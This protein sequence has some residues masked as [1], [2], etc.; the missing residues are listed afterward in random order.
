MTDQCPDTIINV[1]ADANMHASANALRKKFLDAYGEGPGEIHIFFAPGR[2]NLIGEHI[3]Y[4]GGYVLPVALSL[5][6]YAAVRYAGTHP[7]Q[8]NIVHL[9]SVNEPGKVSV[10]LSEE[11]LFEAARGW[12]NY[13]LGVIQ[14]L[15]QHNWSGVGWRLDRGC[16]LG[17]PR[18]TAKHLRG[19]QI[20]YWGNLPVGAGLSSSAAIEVLTGYLMLY[21]SMKDRFDSIQQVWLAQLC[22]KAEN[23]FIKV[24]CG[25]MDQF[26][27]AMGK[28]NQAVLLDCVSLDCRYVPVELGDYS[29][30][31]M[32]T[33]KRRSLRESRYNRRRAE[34]EEALGVIRIHGCCV[35]V[36]NLAQ[37]TLEQLEVLRQTIGIP[38]A[39]G[40]P[41]APE[42]SEAPDFMLARHS[43][44]PVLV[45]RARHVLT[46][47]QRTIQAGEFLS[48]G[49][50]L[51][52]GRLMTES[53][54]SL[55]YD[56]EVTGFELDAIVEAALSQDCC[57]GARMTGAGFGG[58]AIALVR[59]YSLDG[60]K[61]A[62]GKE[63]FLKT[64]LRAEFYVS[65]AGDGVKRLNSSNSNPSVHSNAAPGS[66]RTAGSNAT[67]DANATSD[68]SPTSGFDGTLSD[69]YSGFFA[70]LYDIIH[71]GLGDVE[72]WI[73]FGRRFGPDILE[74]G[75]GTGRIAIPLAK[76]G[77]AVTGIDSSD[78][79]IR[80]CEAKLAME[81]E[82][83][84][85]R[86]SIVKGDITRFQLERQFDLVIAPCNVINH[87]W[88]PEKLFRALTYVRQHLKRPGVFIL[89]NSIPDIQY[90]AGVNGVERVFEFE[91]PLTGTRIVD[92]FKSNY[93]F[94]NQLEHDSMT[95]EEYDDSGNLLR[96]ATSQG[97]MTYFFPR[98]LRLLLESS[99][100]AIFHEQGSLLVDSPI[101]RE[102][103]EMI[104]FCRRDF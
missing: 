99:G 28:R 54:N 30:V 67:P 5:G 27:V 52:F 86:V 3:D 81:D 19:C 55:R 73:E 41:E 83:T 93:D 8:A 21:P 69:Q 70:E 47:N 80:R 7:H 98:E 77:L 96:H 85:S 72:S 104:F 6:I 78:D 36:E 24:Q 60:F 4:N 102:S 57:A 88:E 9:A 75:T 94:V 56:Y 31:I 89:D 64:G 13:P 11:I 39:T 1:S 35:D 45:R 58:C 65:S 61:Q 14:Q 53:H 101:S 62:V 91:H 23:E 71:A 66:N 90:M 63:Y 87:L 79:M 50:I 42:D 33:N 16:S 32:N 100:F 92:R 17:P 2:V 40:V 48:Q 18:N 10:D 29:L 26:A 37:A 12:A 95:I 38:N 25:I 74:L 68:V 34:C 15:Q 22:Q 97:T 84:R 76:A 43:T 59:T 20:L 103:M 51:G 82:D 44:D 49:D 46:E